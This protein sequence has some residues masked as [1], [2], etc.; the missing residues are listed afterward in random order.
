MLDCKETAKL[1]SEM[2]DRRVSLRQRIEV[3]F[4]LAACTLCRTYSKQI[5]LLTRFSRRAGNAVMK[6]DSGPKLSEDC[7][8]RI[9]SRMTGAS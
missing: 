9:K 3:W 8:Q 6:T 2:K 4:H 7:K 1:V 5:D